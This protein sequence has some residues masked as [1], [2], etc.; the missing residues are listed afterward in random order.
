M[1][2]IILYPPPV[3]AKLYITQNRPPSSLL[4]VV[5]GIVEAEVVVEAV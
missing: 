1:F 4:S 2:T 5:V 3:S